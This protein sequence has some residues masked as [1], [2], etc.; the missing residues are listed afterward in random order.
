LIANWDGLV[1]PVHIVFDPEI[2]IKTTDDGADTAAVGGGN[3]DFVA[4]MRVT[5]VI[6]PVTGRLI[7]IRRTAI[8]AP[9]I[10][11]GTRALIKD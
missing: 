11:T 10:V 5:D 3:A 1:R 6:F 8:G 9:V 2:L 7:A 4:F